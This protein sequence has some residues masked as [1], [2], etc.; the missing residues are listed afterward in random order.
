MR[1]IKQDTDFW[2]FSCGF[3][4]ALTKRYI[5]NDLYTCEYSFKLTTVVEMDACH[6]L[7][8]RP[9]QYDMDTTYKG[10]DNTYLFWWHGQKIILVPTGTNN[11]LQRN[12]TT[13]GMPLLTLGEGEFMEEVKASGV[14]LTVVVKGEE[15]VPNAAIPKISQPLLEEF[16]DL[17]PVELPTWLPPMQDI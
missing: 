3:D 16:R 7:L 14:L 15:S 5:A 11:P 10:R 9:W 12:T 2:Q 8:G 1:L 17:T 6:I 4:L 13:G